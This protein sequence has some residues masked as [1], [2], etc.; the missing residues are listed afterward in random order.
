MSLGIYA[1]MH[2]VICILCAIRIQTRVSQQF[3]QSGNCGKTSLVT[4]DC[5][6]VNSSLRAKKQFCRIFAFNNPIWEDSG[7]QRSNLVPVHSDT[8]I[9]VPD[10]M[11]PRCSTSGGNKLCCDQAH[12]RSTTNII[13]V[14]IGEHKHAVYPKHGGYKT[15]HWDCLKMSHT[16]MI[17][18]MYVE[19]YWLKSFDV[20]LDVFNPSYL[21]VQQR[22]PLLW[23]AKA[24]VDLTSTPRTACRPIAR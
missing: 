18:F 19:F 4:A 5:D 2:Y 22:Q 20:P 12:H 17:P 11:I 9:L 10:M 24:L 1:R 13:Y 23:N 15:N 21:R 6:S 16:Q 14:Q 8:S 7:I 3:V